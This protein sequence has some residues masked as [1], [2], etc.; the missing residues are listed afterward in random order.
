M[1]FAD[2]ARLK[3]HQTGHES[4]EKYRCNIDS[5][6]EIFRKQG[7]LDKHQRM[8]HDG[9]DAF[10]CGESNEDGS[11][12]E[13]GF[14]TEYGLKQHKGRIH[15]EK[16]YSCSVCPVSDED[17]APLGLTFNTSDELQAHNAQYHPPIC[18][19]C[20]YAAMTEKDLT[21]HIS[22]SH[23]YPENGSA[24]V[25]TCPFPECDGKT[26][27]RKYGMSTHI[28]TVHDNKRDF[29][30]ST[31]NLESL[32]N[33]FSWTGSDACGRA[34]KSKQGLEEHIRT[35]HLALDNRTVARQ[36]RLGTYDPPG[37]NKKIKTKGQGT[38][39]TLSK[40]TGTSYQENPKRNIPCTKRGCDYM[41]TRQYDLDKHLQ[42][43]HGFVADFHDA[44]NDQYLNS[45]FDSRIPFDNTNA[46][47]ETENEPE[48]ETENEIE[49][50]TDGASTYQDPEKAFA[51]PKN[52]PFWS[53]AGYGGGLKTGVTG[54]HGGNSFG[55]M[56]NVRK[57]D[58]W[59]SE[60]QNLIDN[61]ESSHEIEGTGEEETL[62]LG[63][64]EPIDPQLL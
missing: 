12:C 40:L 50:E 59:R 1:A 47:D 23:S 3:R 46:P 7:T 22:Q 53:I 36:K 14:E 37:P 45:I 32:N 39:T 13:K 41:F 20:A 63:D 2:A 42:T 55:S 26:F 21:N 8:V 61:D 49:F 29:I 24:P 64:L 15:G 58:N 62:D 4:R 11:I 27:T 19:V 16:S 44:F 56:D 30:C 31:V 43:S 6:G 57:N 9:K 48:I 25:F 51:V 18:G 28:K 54:S 35:A 52:G 17:N 5:C 10:T 60:M 33:V 38:D 34:F